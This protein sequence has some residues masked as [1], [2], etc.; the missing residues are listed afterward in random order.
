M[1]RIGTRA[2]HIAW[3]KARALRYVDAG[4]VNNAFASLTADLR[5][6]P[7]TENHPAMELGMMLLMAGH[8]RTPHEMR[9]WIHGVS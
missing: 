8:L 9:E 2:E 6:H 5:S 1:P 7:E 3:C 4:D